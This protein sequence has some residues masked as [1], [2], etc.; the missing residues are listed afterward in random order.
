MSA[1]GRSEH[2]AVSFDLTYN[3]VMVVRGVYKKSLYLMLIMASISLIVLGSSITILYNTGFQEQRQ[4]LIETAKSRARLIEAVARFDQIN[5]GSGSFEATLSQIREAHKQFEGFG[6]TGE[7]TLAKLENNQIVFLLSHRHHDLNNPHPVPF[8]S[9]E[10]EPMRRALQG[11]SGSLVGLDYRGETVLAA[12]EP[13][14]E[15]NLGV[16]AKIDMKEIQAPFF[17]ASGIASGIA[18]LLIIIGSWIFQRITKPIVATMNNINGILPIC[19]WCSNQIRDDDGE[20]VKLEKYIEGRTDTNF[21]HGICPNCAESQ[22]EP[23]SN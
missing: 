7:F 14:K 2:L 4:R 6:D 23:G 13:I 3:R 9:E 12:Y 21:S 11:K 22:T 1:F 5:T 10:A 20:W 17:R 16:V 19:A 18:I 8:G 15:L